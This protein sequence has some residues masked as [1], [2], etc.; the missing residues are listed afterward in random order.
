MAIAQPTAPDAERKVAIRPSPVWL[1][2]AP[3][4]PA[5]A[6]RTMVSCACS[7]GRAPASPSR[8]II[9][10]E[11][12]MSVNMMTSGAGALATAFATP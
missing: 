5:S 2:S 3:P 12:S 9:A 4:W 10:V 6:A 1:T 7:T 8:S 11:P